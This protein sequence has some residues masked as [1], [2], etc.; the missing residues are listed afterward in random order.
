MRRMY[1]Q[2]QLEAIAKAVA[3]N[4][5][6]ESIIWTSQLKY[7]QRYPNDSNGMPLVV[8]SD[9]SILPASLSF[10]KIYKHDVSLLN[11]HAILFSNHDRAFSELTAG[12]KP[13]LWYQGTATIVL[14]G[15]PRNIPLIVL[16]NT[17][18]IPKLPYD[19]LVIKIV[20]DDSSSPYQYRRYY[21]AVGTADSETGIVS[22]ATP[23][24]R[25]EWENIGTDS[26]SML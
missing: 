13:P 25:E 24:P 20:G 15:T 2:K 22:Y 19:F 26:V 11:G 6:S 21:G 14:G 5:I 8:Q 1:S 4:E 3:D 7:K 12:R 23:E 10:S 16:S 17:N 9:G 18:T